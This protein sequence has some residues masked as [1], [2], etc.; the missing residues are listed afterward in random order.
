MSWLISHNPTIKVS[1]GEKK[2]CG[3][4]RNW[5]LKWPMPNFISGSQRRHFQSTIYNWVSV[6]M[7]NK[8][9]FETKYLLSI[10]IKW[11]YHSGFYSPLS[12]VS[13]IYFDVLSFFLELRMKCLNVLRPVNTDWCGLLLNLG[14]ISYCLTWFWRKSKISG[15]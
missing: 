13:F 2:M 4:Y 1:D 10:G 5:C 6:W 11:C 9:A 15:W 7:F 8:M 14:Y 3:P 12:R